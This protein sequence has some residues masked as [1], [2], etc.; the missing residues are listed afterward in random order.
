[1]DSLFYEESLNR[2]IHIYFRALPGGIKKNHGALRSG[3]ILFDI[4]NT[5]RAFTAPSYLDERK[6]RW[7]GPINP[8]TINSID[9]IEEVPVWIDTIFNMGDDI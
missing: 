1:M 7:A 4:L 9:E 6:Y 5:G 2:G 3:D 8:F